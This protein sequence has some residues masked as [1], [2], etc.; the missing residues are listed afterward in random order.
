MGLPFIFHMPPCWS[1]YLFCRLTSSSFT[2]EFLNINV[3]PS[4]DSAKFSWLC[5][6]LW[7]L[8]VQTK[9]NLD[10]LS[11]DYNSC[12]FSPTLC[13]CLIYLPIFLRKISTTEIMT[14]Q[15]CVFLECLFPCRVI[16]YYSAQTGLNWCLLILQTA[17]PSTK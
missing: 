12:T 9:K 4:Y 17:K 2:A 1:M 7:D 13:P 5:A 3:S 11:F 6:K 14:A 16:F 8:Y 15:E 10:F